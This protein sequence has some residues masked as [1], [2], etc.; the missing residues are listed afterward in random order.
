MYSK[1]TILD[2]FVFLIM[3]KEYL[4]F[5][6]CKWECMAPINNRELGHLGLR[7]QSLSYQT[8]SS[9]FSVMLSH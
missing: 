8:L 9:R 2:M 5:I 6:V 3:Q 1:P 7:V 4:I